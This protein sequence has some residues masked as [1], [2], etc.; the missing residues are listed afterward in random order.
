M[1]Y[2]P[3]AFAREYMI[4]CSEIIKFEDSDGKQ[5]DIRCVSETNTSF[6]I[7][8][9]C[10]EFF[11]DIS[12]KEGDVCLFELIKRKDVVL[13]VSVLRAA[14]YAAMVHQKK[15]Y[16]SVENSHEDEEDVKPDI[17]G[18]FG[19]GAPRSHELS[20]KENAEVVDSGTLYCSRMIK[21][22]SLSRETKRAIEAARAL[23]IENP[24]FMVILQRHNM[25]N[26][27]VVKTP[28]RTMC[29]PGLEVF[30]RVLIFKTHTY[31]N[32]I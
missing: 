18:L 28:T 26:Y 24:A 1:Q 23:K 21:K 15:K 8:K 11:R 31:T 5:W 13:K 2:V 32:T 22:I 17:V 9:G 6:R 14:E 29:S 7:G 3:S 16:T 19:N 25:H 10:S 30:P 20:V 12:L 4:G 27:I